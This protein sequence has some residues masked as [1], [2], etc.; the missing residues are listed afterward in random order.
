[1]N[2]CFTC[3]L[4]YSAISRALNEHVFNMCLT[5]GKHMYYMGLTCLRHN[6]V[7]SHLKH[8]Y[9]ISCKLHKYMHQKYDDHCL[10]IH[11]HLLT[12][13]NGSATAQKDRNFSQC[14]G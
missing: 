1:M 6:A 9:L 3:V 11:P 14:G 13:L 12:L 2:M 7:L 5:C 8:V 10:S 4:L